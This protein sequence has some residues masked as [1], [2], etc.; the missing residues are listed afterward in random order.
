MITY[1]YAALFTGIMLLLAGG[2]TMGRHILLEPI[3]THY[4]KAPLF[5]RNAMFAFAAVLVFLGLR[6]IWVYADGQPDTIPPQP[7]PS[8]QLLAIALVGYKGV[9]LTNI[10]RQRYSE[11]IWERLNRIN[12]VLRCADGHCFK[13]WFS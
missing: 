7:D 8:I 5:V 9:M 3:S 2:L 1:P 4:P 12:E 13:R 6:F 11:K 10:V